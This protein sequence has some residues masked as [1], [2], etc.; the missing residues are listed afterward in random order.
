MPY[1]DPRIHL[2]FQSLYETGYEFVI[3]QKEYISEGTHEKAFARIYTRIQMVGIELL[4]YVQVS[5][6]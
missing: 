2:K 5:I 3:L 1:N 6:L 4:L